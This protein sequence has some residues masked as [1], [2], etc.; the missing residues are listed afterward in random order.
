MHCSFQNSPMQTLHGAPCYLPASS[1][2]IHPGLAWDASFFVSTVA[3]FKLTT[4]LQILCALCAAPD[5][6]SFFILCVYDA[7]A[8]FQ[9]L[10]QFGKSLRAFEHLQTTQTSRSGERPRSTASTVPIPT[11]PS[12]EIQGS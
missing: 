4:Q 1:H 12:L 10:N 3:L 7:L 11:L 8:T 2:H 9:H 5:L 6:S